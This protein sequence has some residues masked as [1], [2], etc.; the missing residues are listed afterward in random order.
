[1]PVGLSGVL[2]AARAATGGGDAP[3]ALAA[4]VA[5]ELAVPKYA[6]ALRTAPVDNYLAIKRGADHLTQQ[7]KVVPGSTYV[8]RLAAIN[9][10]G[11]GPFSQWRLFVAPRAQ[12]A[13]PPAPAAAAPPTPEG[14]GGARPP[15]AGVAPAEPPVVA[16][17]AP[18]AQAPAAE[19]AGPPV[20]GGGLWQ[21]WRFVLP[22]LLCAVGALALVVL[23]GNSGV[24][25]APAWVLVCG[26]LTLQFGY[27]EFHR[28]EHEVV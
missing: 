19:V 17:E 6:A 8:V 22:G 5:A 16:G 18:A 7:K 28:K 25:G 24:P 3:D 2:A 9:V 27:H 13:G 20:G 11:R 23:A 15:Q 26:T 10:A 14:G 21:R 1:V 12:G 4:A